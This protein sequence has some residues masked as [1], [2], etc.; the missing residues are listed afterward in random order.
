MEKLI[1]LLLCILILST[2]LSGSTG[3]LQAQGVHAGMAR[4]QGT[5]ALG[6]LNKSQELRYYLYGEGEYLLD[7]HWGLNGAVY[8]Q[9][10]SSK[11]EF[12]DNVSP[13]GGNYLTHSL[14]S[15]PVYHF[16]PNTP[17]DVY[18][19]VQPGIHLTQSP[20][21]EY[22]FGITF[23]QAYDIHPAASLNVGA[24]YYGSFFH[25]FAQLRAVTGHNL[26]AG[27]V[28]GLAELRPTF[29]LGFNLF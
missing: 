13:S 15:G 5:L 23:P 24:A 4:V 1:R 18:V 14:F 16:R 12:S 22:P 8:A 27:T 10:G 28:Y 20:R 2:L 21:V 6:L 29:G 7:D 26:K 3:A 17:L 11:Q 9:M 19:A 25:L